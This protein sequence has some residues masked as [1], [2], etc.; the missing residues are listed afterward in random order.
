MMEPAI[1]IT[2]L[3][4][5]D[6]TNIYAMQEVHAHMARHGQVYFALEQTR[7]RGQR[8]REWH[9]LPGTNIMMS[10]VFDVKG[11][12]IEH[13]FPFNMAIALGCFDFLSSRAGDEVSVKWPNDIYWRDRKAGGILIENLIQQGE[14]T[15]A[16]AGIG[17]NINQTSFD[18]SITRPAVS[19]TQIT[20]KTF[21]LMELLQDLCKKILNRWEDFKRSP[22]AMVVDFENRMYKKD[23]WI[24]LK[25]A[26]RILD[27]RVLGVNRY[28]QLRVFTTLEETFGHGDIEWL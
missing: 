21:D 11:L 1:D 20:G 10:M 14:W 7:G 3:P 19:L 9:S 8:G 12:S 17:I 13:Q 22:E 16:I 24:R 23:Q 6:S 28:G 27:A 5:V 26:N 15:W 4:T 25:R 18:P 2:V